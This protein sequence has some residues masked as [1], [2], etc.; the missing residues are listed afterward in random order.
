MSEAQKDNFRR[1]RPD[2]SLVALPLA[3]DETNEE[4]NP[5]MVPPNGYVDGGVLWAGLP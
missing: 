4:W 2:V 5:P 3:E 1:A